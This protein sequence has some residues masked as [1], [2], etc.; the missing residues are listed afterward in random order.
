MNQN[1]LQKLHDFSKSYYN[2]ENQSSYKFTINDQITSFYKEYARFPIVSLPPADAETNLATLIVNRASERTYS[3]LGLTLQELS[4]L[5]QYSCGEFTRSDGFVH[6]AQPSGG[7]LYPIEVYPI[8]RFSASPELVP[9]VYHY[10]VKSHT[11][12]YMWQNDNA[13]VVSDHL[14]Q[15]DWAVTAS[16]MLVMTSVFW[17]SQYKYKDRS[18]RYIC[19]EAGAIMQN[20]YLYAS[21][22]DL[23]VVGYGGI[24]DD[25]VEH[26]LRL[27]TKIESVLSAILVGK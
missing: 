26:L 11:L 23:K 18:Y 4:N 19:M 12:E 20:A 5:L 16:V 7:I 22:S 14:V 9:G 25:V 27:D 10:N 17:R 15:H 1:A 13:G 2:P 3:D 21:D 6:R 24:N 8:V